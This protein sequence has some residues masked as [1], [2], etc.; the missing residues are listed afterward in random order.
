MSEQ[1]KPARGDDGSDDCLRYRQA[2]SYTGIKLATLYALVHQQRVPHFRLSGR[3]VLF[4]KRALDA[5]L[6]EHAVPATES[7]T[8]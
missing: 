8:R 2:S 7:S 6:A 3:L 1:N 4:S 5:W